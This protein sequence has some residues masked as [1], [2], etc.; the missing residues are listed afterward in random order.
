MKI[1]NLCFAI[2]FFILFQAKA[3]NYIVEIA[4]KAENYSTYTGTIDYRGTDGS[5]SFIGDDPSLYTDEIDKEIFMNDVVIKGILKNVSTN[6]NGQLV[7]ECDPGTPVCFTVHSPTEIVPTI[8]QNYVQIPK[9]DLQMYANRLSVIDYGLEGF[10]IQ[11]QD[12]VLIEDI[13][14]YEMLPCGTAHTIC[15]DASYIYQAGNVYILNCDPSSRL[16]VT[17]NLGN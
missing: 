1:L 17:L 5:V 16:C 6:G 15:G 9:L 3:Q 7:V 13:I 14:G 2:I 12:D 11:M 8:I 10:A 4:Y